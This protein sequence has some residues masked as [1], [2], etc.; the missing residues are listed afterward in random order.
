MTKFKVGDHVVKVNDDLG[1]GYKLGDEI[2][3]DRIVAM[4]YGPLLCSADRAGGMWA[5][6]AAHV[7]PVDPVDPVDHEAAPAGDFPADRAPPPAPA[8]YLAGRPAQYEPRFVI[9]AWDLG[10]NLGSA[11]KYIA[12]AGRKGGPADHIRDL[13]KARDFLKFEIERLQ[14]AGHYGKAE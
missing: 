2:T 8:H 14:G 9:A 5:E 13:E 7:D 11:V 4:S 12:R 1:D 6:N 10:Y 3:V